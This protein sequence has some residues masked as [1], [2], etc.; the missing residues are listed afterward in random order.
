MGQ[1]HIKAPD[2]REFLIEGPDGAS[3]EEIIAITRSHM[4]KEAPDLAK[5][6]V[7]VNPPASL[8]DLAAQGATLGLSDEAAGV[9][10]M[11]ANGIVAPFSPSVDFDPLAAYQRGRDGERGALEAKREESPWASFLAEGVGSLGAIGPGVAPPRTLGGM[12]RQGAKQGGILGSLGGFGYGEGAGGSI[13]GAGLGGTGGTVLGGVL[14]LALRAIERP[15]RA[16]FDF[17]RPRNGV[18]RE[19][20][21]RAMRED[22]VAPSAAAARMTEGNANGVPLALMDQGDNLRGLA[23][24]LSRRPGASRTL[25]REAVIDRQA[26]QG[27]RVRGAIERDLGPIVNPMD[28]GDQLIQQARTAAKPLYEKAYSNPGASVVDMQDLAGRPSFRKAL[29]KA[30]NLAAEEGDN[31]M[32]LGFQ[33]DEAGDVLLTDVPSFKTMDYIKRGLDD[34]VEG[35]RDSTTG[36]LNLNT[37]EAR[38]TNE[39]LRTFISRMDKVN[40]DYA[41]A[42]AAYAGPAKQREALDMG[43]KSVNMSA[44]EIQRL[45][46]NMGDDQIEQFL[47]G[48][49]AALAETLDRR[50]DGADKANALLGTPRKRQALGAL[51]EG[52]GD[53][54]RFHRTLTDE[55]AAAETYRTVNTGSPTAQRQIDDQMTADPSMLE[56]VAGRAVRGASNGLSGLTAEA[57]GLLKDVGRFGAGATGQ[58]AREDAAALISNTDPALFQEAMRA[59]L[60]DQALNRVR[61]SNQGRILNY[62]GNLGARGAGSLL[63]HLSK[64]LEEGR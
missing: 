30:A 28:Q 64:P 26:G 61:Q 53:L 33:F 55:Q 23:G 43:R 4:E 1:Y 19:L 3:E 7:N 24:S 62:T 9:G 40:P 60:R 49:R 18:G 54:A 13:L 58:R 16:G 22:M 29:Q 15:I 31:P 63:G 17:M 48:H 47:S 12:M 2:G 46:Q 50:V 57:I 44:D 38:A 6:G 10:R 36:K 59:A 39:T 20:V 5:S 56:D 25:V 42:R 52:R 32:A 34:V 21:S 11:L 35:F 41:A 8:T 14:P 51:Y 27:E 45:T 37:G